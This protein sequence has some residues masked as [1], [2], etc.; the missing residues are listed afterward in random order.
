MKQKKENNMIQFT[1]FAVDTIA[2]FIKYNFPCVIASVDKNH[3]VIDFVKIVS[4]D[5][6]QDKIEVARFNGDVSYFKY[7]NLL[8]EIGKILKTGTPMIL[9]SE[10]NYKKYQSLIM[11]VE[12]LNKD[13]V[14]ESLLIDYSDVNKYYTIIFPFKNG[15]PVKIYFFELNDDLLVI[16]DKGFDII[17]DEKFTSIEDVICYG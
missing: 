16:N 13:I 17:M 8:K 5:A 12:K 9:V 3:T 1:D 6:K 4:K 11:C 14:K 10:E 7:E 2:G 15:K